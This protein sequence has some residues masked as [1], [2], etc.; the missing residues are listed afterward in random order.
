MKLHFTLWLKTIAFTVCAAHFYATA[1]GATVTI[2]SPTNNATVTSTPITISG[3]SSQ[4]YAIV[5]LSISTT[6]IGSTTTDISGNWNFTLQT[7][8]NGTYALTATLMDS[9]FGILATTTNTFTMTNPETITITNPQY[10]TQIFA[11][12]AIISGTSS[13]ANGLVNIYLD[14]TLITTATASNNSWSTT[15]TLNSFGAHT[16]AAQLINNGSMVATTTVNSLSFFSTQVLGGV[17]RVDALF[18]NDATGK[19]NSLPFA[20]INAALAA[21]QSG[22]LVWILPGTYA[23]SFTIPDGVSVRGASLN[24]VKITKTVTTATDLVTMGENTRLEDVSLTVTSNSH[25]QLRG[26]VFPGTTSATAKLR[27]STITV[28]NSGAGAG[29]SNV[30]GVHSTGT[31]L[32]TEDIAAIRACNITVRSAGLGSK[33]GILVNSASDFHMRDT[34]ILVTNSGGGAAIGV[35]T[36]HASAAFTARSS[37]ISGSSADISQTQGIMTIVSTD[38]LNATANGLP[39]TTKISPSILVWA[40]SGTLPAGTNFMHVG[41]DTPL[42]EMLVYLPQATIVKAL[43]VRTKTAPGSTDTFT[44]FKNGITTG[45]S[46][47]LTTPNTFAINNTQSVTFAAG[48]SISLQLIR[49]LSGSSETVVT[50]QLY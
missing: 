28:D 5:R 34:S 32:P 50:A 24:A 39:F 6:I 10:N 9:G 35:E 41:T 8:N 33:R 18:G 46:V 11:N 30:Y 23:E 29:T 20:T 43:S 17:L 47:S 15:Y 16:L 31:G 48:D 13:L 7:L 3:T 25:V 19:R 12:P 44:I 38:L 14:G 49:G 21:A 4:A 2:T 27:T 40:D 22:D 45:M 37:T 36:N 42:N 1:N 26:I